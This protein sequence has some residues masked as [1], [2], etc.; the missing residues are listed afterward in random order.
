MATEPGTLKGAATAARGDAFVA[1]KLA[2]TEQRIRGLDLAAAALGF[3]AGSCVYAAV[4]IALDR[5]LAGAETAREL[6]F[7][8]YLAGASAYLAIFVAKPLTRRINPYF[9]ARQVERSLPGAKN[10]VVNWVDLH[11]QP[12]PPA[13][14]NALGVRAA[15]DLARVDLETAVSA[16][17]TGIAGGVAAVAAGLLVALLLSMGGGPFFDGLARAFAP[18]R[19]PGPARTRTSLTLLRPEAGNATVMVGRGLSVAVEVSGKLPDPKGPDA[20]R[21]QYR[22]GEDDPWLERQMTP[23]SGSEFSATVSAT[24]VRSGFWYKVSGGDA[25]TA[26][27]RVTVCSTP[28][29][30]DF[31]A[32]YH[33]PKYAAVPKQTRSERAL[34]A[35]R[36][37]EAAVW[38]LTNRTL[39]EAHLDFDGKNGRKTIPGRVVAGDPQSFQAQ[40]P[41]DESGLYRLGFTSVD[42]DTFS[43][44]FHPVEVLA[45]FPPEVELTRPGADVSLPANGLLAL[46]GR[47]SDDF[48]VRELTLRMQAAD[49]ALKPRPYRSPDAL[50]LPG[51]GYPQVV[52]YKD[53]IDLA[54]LQADDF[55]PFQSKP[56]ME[57]EYWLEAADAREPKPN[58]GAS[59]HY[60]VKLGE[61]QKDEV[62][63]QKDREQAKKEQQQHEAKQDEQLQKESANRQDQEQEADQREQQHGKSQDDKGNKGENGSQG[64]S[65]GQADKK[66]GNAG[67][68]NNQP[69]NQDQQNQTG[70]ESKESTGNGGSGSQERSNEDR[71]N[72]E[73]AEKLKKALNKNT[74]DSKGS[75]DSSE[76]GKEG[77]K[78]QASGSG[79][80]GEQQTGKQTPEDDKRD[81][82]NGSDKKEGARKEGD[83]RDSAKSTPSSA[84]SS[85]KEQGDNSQE[86]SSSTDGQKSPGKSDQER[87]GTEPKPKDTADSSSAKPKGGDQG[88]KSGEPASK[89]SAGQEKNGS[90]KSGSGEKAESGNE[91][92]NRDKANGKQSGSGDSKAKPDSKPGDAKGDNASADRRPK[93]DEGQGNQRASE[94]KG[95]ADDKN[96]PGKQQGSESGQGNKDPG[97]QT[98][99]EKDSTGSS[100]DKRNAAPGSD[101]MDG[102]KSGEKTEQKPAGKDPGAENQLGSGSKEKPEQGNPGS[103]KKEHAGTS[104]QKKGEAERNHGQKEP[105]GSSAP[106]PS[107]PAGDKKNQPKGGPPDSGQTKQSDAGE[108]QKDLKKSS[109][110]DARN[111]AKDLRSTDPAKRENAASK[112]DQMSKQ[113]DNPKTR[114]EA[115]KALDD[116]KND[117]HSKDP[118]TARENSKEEAGNPPKSEKNAEEKVGT[119]GKGDEKNHG[120][121]RAPKRDQDTSTKEDRTS[122]GKKDEQTA[123]ET[124]HQ[125]PKQGDPKSPAAPQD[126]GGKES[127]GPSDKQ[128][129][130]QST[131]KT[132]TGDKGTREG[133]KGQESTENPDRSGR[134]DPNRQGDSTGT[135]KNKSGNVAEGDTP[136]ERA[137]TN[138]R[139]NE[140][141][142]EPPPP[143]LPQKQQA[144]RFLDKKTDL[145]LED[146]DKVT[147]KD[148]EAA[149]LTD[150]DLAALREW[151]KDQKKRA[152]AADPKDSAVAP[153]QGGKGRSFGGV[154]V[155]PGTG[156]KPND[157]SGGSRALPP[158]GYQEANEEFKRMLNKSEPGGP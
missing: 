18:F 54:G 69:Q 107:N 93:K 102:Q 53:A 13:I 80:G 67:D 132:G 98:R 55:G 131:E 41:L 34:R 83:K 156:G 9:A 143:A 116:A 144:P 85:A 103:D 111:A 44:P 70:A 153:Q 142:D 30:T 43:E 72:A 39:R 104:D 21:L 133:D 140:N 152:T 128:P 110:D 89:P 16:R 82:A 84:K 154:R 74:G 19:H 101:K 127:G 91:P 78:G 45:D 119:A 60:H 10:S 126:E 135:A 32:T 77:D 48:G 52:A 68:Q 63:Q 136:G 120:Q 1:D 51:G 61:P 27:Y 121:E 122:A 6:L 81:P 11:G 149:K 56:G 117:A 37:S 36:G 115:R 65:P 58:I 145:Q 87:K 62:K 22:Y 155:Q 71:K 114:D 26:E 79:N 129:G 118:G 108:S 148:L 31:Q 105:Q 12:L 29:L 112:L 75:S 57:I 97:Q 4:M 95:P 50:H 147:K 113:A 100:Q 35:V 49:R 7:V 139:Q 157:L 38:A 46:E 66:D 134:R 150:K 138:P 137:P 109:P 5:L 86:G 59:K 47:A 125:T 92:N 8:C 73:N 151:L 28:Q 96:K 15:K 33:F 42:G 123:K 20:V 3:V 2:R 17:R 141:T 40:L 24:E 14:R 146:L 158:P 76:G 88:E 94:T 64:Q 23:E 106:D 90:G 124:E 130:K 99:T 25:E